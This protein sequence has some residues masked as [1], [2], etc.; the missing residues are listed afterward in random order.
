MY[1]PIFYDPRQNVDGLDSFSKSAGKP[2]RF[3]QVM[4][5]LYFRDYGHNTSVFEPLTKAD[6]YRVHATAYVD[7]VFAGTENNGFGNKDLRLPESCLWTAG[8][9]LAASRWAL[10]YPAI[11]ACSPT[12]GFHHAGHDFGGGY[13]TFNGI[14]AV[15]AKLL[16]ENPALKIGILDCDMHYGDGTQNILLHRS[17]SL[18]MPPQFVQ[19]VIHRTAGEHFLGD[20]VGSESLEFFAWLNHSI[21]ELNEFGCDLVIYQAGADQHID[22]PLGGILNTA[23]MAQRDRMV[24]RGVRAGIAWNLAGGYQVSKNDDV[25]TDPV[26]QLHRDTLIESQKSTDTRKAWRP[27]PIEKDEE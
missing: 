23:E 20:D 12:S 5:H 25:F 15:A 11:P 7:G 24:F 21:D 26:I 13:C 10:Q 3:V 14:M 22:D 8:S 16:S 18:V 1:T 19:N 9:L 27:I 4:K 6:L 17:T 2:A